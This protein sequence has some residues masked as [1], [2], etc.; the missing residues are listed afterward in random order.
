MRPFLADGTALA[1]V[2][3]AEKVRSTAMS[4]AP[5]SR[6]A[7]DACMYLCAT[8]GCVVVKKLPKSCKSIA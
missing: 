6:E 7:P 2:G 5:L 4:S 1:L 8:D 3:T